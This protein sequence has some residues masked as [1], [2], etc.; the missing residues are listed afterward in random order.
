MNL[1]FLNERVPFGELEMCWNRKIKMGRYGCTFLLGSESKSVYG[2]LL[3]EQTIEPCEE[4]DSKLYR[5]TEHLAFSNAGRQFS[6][7]EDFLKA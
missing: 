4:K 2:V 3:I 7:H 1:I 6:F 5:D